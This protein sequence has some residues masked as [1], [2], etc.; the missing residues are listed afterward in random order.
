MDRTVRTLVIICAISLLINFLQY[1]CSRCPDIDPVILTKREIKFDTTEKIINK[2][3]PY[4]VP[5]YIIKTDTVEVPANV[6]TA[7]ILRE[8]F[9]VNHY[10]WEYRDTLLAF[11][12]SDEISQNKIQKREA[13]YKIL[14]PQQIINNITTVKKSEATG[15][16]YVGFDIGTNLKDISTFGPS[17]MYATKNKG[18][19][20]AGYDPF[21][22]FYK[23][24]LY[25]KLFGK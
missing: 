2:S 19:I 6:D 21:N 23:A 9:A 25:W 18:A 8:Y 10:K 7:A 17:V 12:L 16:F 22:K 20:S 15:K 11:D 4:Y 24:G 5:Y 1:S 3:T 13:S 14:R